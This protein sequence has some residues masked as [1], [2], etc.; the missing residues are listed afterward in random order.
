MWVRVNNLTC[1]CPEAALFSTQFTVGQIFI[2]FFHTQK[3]KYC[4]V[5]LS[6]STGNCVYEGPA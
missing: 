3:L 4:P 6:L 5:R 2:A 1:K